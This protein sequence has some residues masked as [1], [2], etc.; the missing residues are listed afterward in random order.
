MQM[1]TSAPARQATPGH[2]PVELSLEARMA[3]VDAAMTVRLDE[4]TAAYEVNTA[5]IPTDPVNLA[6]VV[7]VP[8]TPALSPRLP[9]T[10]VADLLKRARARMDADGWCAGALTNQQGAVCLLGAIRNESGG[11][12]RL[13]A[14]ATELVLD[15][16]R[17][18][19]GDDV[20]SVPGFN[21]SWNNGRVPLRMLTA[22]ADL[23]GARGI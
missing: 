3:A 9:G 1:L 19:F 13:E 6:D 18:H 11:N 20:D 14:D 16:I 4:A 15:A 22:A 23:A 10:P 17:H 5:H 12:S 2:E 7:T 8:L 21:D